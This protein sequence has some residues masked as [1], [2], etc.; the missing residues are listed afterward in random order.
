LI[1]ESFCVHQNGFPGTRHKIPQSLFGKMGQLLKLT[2]F[3]FEPL[4]LL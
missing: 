2:V 1:E 4:I 3:Q